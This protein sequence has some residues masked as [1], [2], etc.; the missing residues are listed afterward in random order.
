MAAIK[1]FGILRARINK[2]AQRPA[3][4]GR[5]KLW[6]GK[7]PGAVIRQPRVTDWRRLDL[8]RRLNLG[9]LKKN[10][11]TE[12]ESPQQRPGELSNCNPRL[13]APA[14]ARPQQS[15]PFVL[16]RT[17]LKTAANDRAER[18]A[19]KMGAPSSVPP[20]PASRPPLSRWKKALWLNGPRPVRDLKG[21]PEPPIPACPTGRC[22]FFAGRSPP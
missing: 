9:G 3:P 12:R 15:G 6:W 20:A 4:S 18:Q 22:F 19:K 17:P 10:E 11:S 13:N 21:R 8:A 2:P 5:R 7:T 16:A 1:R 14:L